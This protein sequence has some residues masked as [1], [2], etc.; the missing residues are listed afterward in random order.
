MAMLLIRGLADPLCRKLKQS[1]ARERRSIARQAIMLPE[2]A[3]APRPSIGSSGVAVCWRNLKLVPSSN[4]ASLSRRRQ[5][6][7]AKIVNGALRHPASRPD[8]CRNVASTQPAAPIRIRL[9][10]ITA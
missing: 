1:A 5:S 8:P 4:R 10:L 9:V 7:F 2:A 6:L 3:P